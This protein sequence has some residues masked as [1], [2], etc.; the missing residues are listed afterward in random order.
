VPLTSFVTL[1]SDLINC[2]KDLS[3]FNQFA[4]VFLVYCL[5]RMHFERENFFKLLKTVFK[6]A[7]IETFISYSAVNT[8]HLSYKSRQVNFV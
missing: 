2:K 1:P 4:S 5:L 6:L 8:I 3:D 7:D